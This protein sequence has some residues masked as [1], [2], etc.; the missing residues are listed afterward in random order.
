MWVFLAI[1]LSAVAGGCGQLRRRSLGTLPVHGLT[2]SP[3]R[4][5]VRPSGSSDGESRGWYVKPGRSWRHIV[6]HHSATDSG[7]AGAFDKA[8]RD[9]GWDELGY[10]FVI[11]NGDG[12]V[13]GEV[14]VGTRWRKQKHGAHCGGTPD[15]EYNEY[16]IGICLVGDFTESLP[17]DAQLRALEALVDYLVQTYSVSP[18]AVIGHRDAP[19]ASTA[20]P[21]DQLDAYVRRTLLTRLAR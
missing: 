9:R 1:A 14:E 11:T 2:L 12:G 17:S 6:I 13:D 21:G 18:R 20:C 3:R 7:S 19:H 5:A 16:G 8:H 10:H 4:N 15:N